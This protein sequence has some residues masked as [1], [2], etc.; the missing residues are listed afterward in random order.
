MSDRC[1]CELLAEQLDRA[2]QRICLRIDKLET[3]I[4]LLDKGLNSQK[5]KL[6]ALIILVAG[7]VGGSASEIVKL[8]TG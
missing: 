7:T 8:I 6:Y 1:V 3:K 5:L 4:E 2:E